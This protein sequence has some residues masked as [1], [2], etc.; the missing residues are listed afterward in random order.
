MV[1]T[2]VSNG[3]VAP[4]SWS[5]RP[6]LV[7]QVHEAHVG[8]GGLGDQLGDALQDPVQVQA[9]RDGLDHLGQELRL[10]LRVGDPQPARAVAR[11]QAGDQWKTP[12]RSAT[13]TAPA[14]SDTPSLR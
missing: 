13:A 14:R 7:E 1:P 2:M 3:G 12:S 6:S 4:R 9:G 10:P 11:T 5:L 8:L